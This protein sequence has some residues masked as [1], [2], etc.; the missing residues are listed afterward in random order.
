MCDRDKPV[1]H[2]CVD[3][4]VW[5]GEGQKSHSL[6]SFDF[7]SPLTPPDHLYDCS[8]GISSEGFTNIILLI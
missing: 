2:F 5:N 8:G 7:P 1:A 3:M 6:R 4:I